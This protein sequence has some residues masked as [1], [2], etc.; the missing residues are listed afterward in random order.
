[1]RGLGRWLVVSTALALGA[2]VALGSSSCSDCGGEPPQG[3]YAPPG[4]THQEACAACASGYTG[5]RDGQWIVIPC[6][7]AMPPPR[8]GGR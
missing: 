2:A 3:C 5:C 8:D 4:A 1:V 7:A 6:G